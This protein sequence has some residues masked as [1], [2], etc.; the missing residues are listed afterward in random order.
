MRT[1]GGG[2]GM[3]KRTIISNLSVTDAEES[4]LVLVKNG[5]EGWEELKAALEAV[6]SRR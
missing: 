5:V 3:F 2:F 4:P 1:S 6:L